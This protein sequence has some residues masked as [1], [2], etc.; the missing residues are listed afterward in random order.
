MPGPVSSKMRAAWASYPAGESA[1]TCAT[2]EKKIKL[3]NCMLLEYCIEWAW[4]A[5]GL[6]WRAARS[7]AGGAPHLLKFG[8]AAAVEEAA[9]VSGTTG[10]G[11]FLQC[12]AW[13]L[14]ESASDSSGREKDWIYVIRSPGT[15]SGPGPTPAGVPSTMGFQY[16]MFRQQFSP[17]KWFLATQMYPNFEESSSCRRR[18]TSFFLFLSCNIFSIKYLFTLT[19]TLL[20]LFYWELFK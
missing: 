15:F 7:R 17:P 19:Q 12:T 13:S 14:P 4:T 11:L 3:E 20:Y 8:P 10:T 1:T 9:A 6:N 16:V 18:L 2:Q 5:D